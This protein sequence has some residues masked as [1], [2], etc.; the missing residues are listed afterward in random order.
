[1][2]LLYTSITVPQSIAAENITVGHGVTVVS[3]VLHIRIID[4]SSSLQ[5]AGYTLAIGYSFNI[6]C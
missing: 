4:V 5:F 1:M 3:N 2:S 6:L